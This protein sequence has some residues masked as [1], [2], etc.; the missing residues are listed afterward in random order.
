MMGRQIRNLTRLIDDLLDVS[1]IARG[2]IELHREALDLAALVARTLEGVRPR[3]EERRLGLD[4]AWPPHPVRV[5]ADPV[6]L[7]Q[8]FTNLLDNAAKFTEP[9]GRVGV[10]VET[11]EG[12]AVVRVSDTGVGIPPEM[13]GH[14]FEPF[15]HVERSRSGPSQWGLGIGLTLVRSLVVLHGGRV[16]AHSGGIGT[17]SEFVVR[18]PLMP[19][20][21]PPE[22]AARA[23]D[24]TLAGG[25]LRILVVDD[26][27]DAADS[28]AILLRLAGHDV[29]TAYG[30]P[31]A[32]QI[33]GHFRPR[34]VLLDLGMPGMDGYEVARRLRQGP[35]AAMTV[36]VA[37]TGWGQD[38]DRRRSREAGFQHHLVKPVEPDA[39]AKL[40]S[41]IA[42]G[43]A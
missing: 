6:R 15:T 24:E 20:E 19:E 10:R 37:L 42:T 18:L 8:V 14:I 34:L 11:T 4:L 9:G 5:E 21:R 32:L 29:R 2:K 30:G 33:A 12:E 23:E 1:R 27:R 31:E 26:S 38:E 28:L 35:S 25:P 36:L 22:P 41:L 3:L 43:E 17:G 40:V 16:E 13:L 39:L 7:E